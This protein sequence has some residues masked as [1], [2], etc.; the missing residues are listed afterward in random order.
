M[1]QTMRQPT[2]QKTRTTRTCIGCGQRDDA[3]ALV[4]LALAGRDVVCQTRSR[5]GRGAHVHPR[6]ACIVGAPRALS[7]A[8]RASVH[9]DARE[10]GRRIAT[11]SEQRMVDLLLVARRR[12]ALAVGVEAASTALDEGAPLAIVA[13]DAGPA[14]GLAPVHA[15]VVAGRAF[16]WR[17][18]GELGSLLTEEEVA[19]CAIRDD[20]IA[21]GLKLMRAAV[22]AGRMA[23]RA[24]EGEACS[25]RPEA[26]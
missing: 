6:A 22:D 24:I 20:Q 18:K 5:R 3:A 2:Q 17:A 21:S 13:V 4:R 12:G 14:R 10:L 15:A 1:M 16:A 23:A 9:A 25:K 11:A 7:R 19:I 8:F 26:R